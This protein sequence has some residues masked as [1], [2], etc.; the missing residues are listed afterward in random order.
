MHHT[1]MLGGTCRTFTCRPF[2]TALYHV[3]R[4]H[5]G[6]RPRPFIAFIGRTASKNL[7]RGVASCASYVFIVSIH[8]ANRLCMHMCALEGRLLAPA[9]RATVVIVVCGRHLSPLSSIL[10]GLD[11][12][13]LYYLLQAAGISGCTTTESGLL[14]SCFCFRPRDASGYMYKPQFCQPDLSGC[15]RLE[16]PQL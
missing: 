2:T 8:R 15:L 12:R 4:S 6:L 14:A 3:H 16:A 5:V 10:L 1:L 11:P 7:S 9:G 13:C